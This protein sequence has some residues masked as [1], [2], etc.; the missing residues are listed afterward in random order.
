[1]GTAVC[2]WGRAYSFSVILSGRKNASALDRTWDIRSTESKDL[3]FVGMYENGRW[4]LIGGRAGQAH[5]YGKLSA[6][7]CGPSS[8]RPVH[9]YMYT[10]YEFL[11][12]SKACHLPLWEGIVTCF[13]FNP[14]DK[15]S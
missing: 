7:F 1:M 8:V 4:Y 14:C 5:F 2:H 6:S 15:N 13:T 3:R 12:D 10:T 9:T 11:C